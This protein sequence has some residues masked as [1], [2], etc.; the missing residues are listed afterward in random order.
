[1]FKIIK[2]VLMTL[3]SMVAVNACADSDTVTIVQF[4]EREKGIDPYQVRY[5]FADE[6]LR[7]DDNA[8]EGN[9]IIYDD[10]KRIIY[11]VNHDDSTI[12]TIVNKDWK[13]P[14]FEFQRNVTWKLIDG[15]PAF[16]SK[17]VYNYWLSAN[18]TVCT[19]AQVVEGFLLKQAEMLMRYRSTLSAGQV[20]SLAA[21]P[22]DMRTPCLLIDNVY[23]TGSVY[24]K[25]FPIQQWHLN[26]LQRIMTTYKKGEKFKAALFDLPTQYKK[27]S[28]GDN[29]SFGE[30]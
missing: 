30:R 9:F 28:M 25:G 5:I 12:L 10:K 21:T 22:E 8:D 4:D 2:T 26:G 11:S 27:Y 13:L 29:L 14:T 1:M 20:D 23:N 15:A 17:P 6:M 7:V 24:E 16:D 18:E 3:L 19:E